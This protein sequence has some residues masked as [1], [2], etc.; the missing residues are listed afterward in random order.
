M[1]CAARSAPS[2]LAPKGGSPRRSSPSRRPAA[3]R[4][5]SKPTS[6]RVPRRLR[7]DLARLKPLARP[8][9]TITAGNASGLNDGACVRAAARPSSAAARHGLE[10]IARVTAHGERRRGAARDGSSGRCPPSASCWRASG[11]SLGDYD[12]VELNEAFAAQV[13]ACIARSG[14]R[15]TPRTST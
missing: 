15:T 5:G 9:G 4:S 3:K 12:V 10:P 11:R 2:A 14:S 6:S 1:R 13:L 8:G 7:E